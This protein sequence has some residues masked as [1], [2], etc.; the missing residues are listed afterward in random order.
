MSLAR[1]CSIIWICAM[2]ALTAA[3]EKPASGHTKI[4]VGLTLNNEITVGTRLGLENVV[5]VPQ[6]TTGDPS[7]KDIENMD[8]PLL[9]GDR[10]HRGRSRHR[11]AHPYGNNYQRPMGYYGS[12]PAGYA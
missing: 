11:K 9:E 7:L 12:G 3:K 5:V 10:R 4:G 6:D 2:I 8:D 1:M